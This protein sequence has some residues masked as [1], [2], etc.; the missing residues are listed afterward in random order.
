MSLQ[1]R[2]H[3]ISSDAVTADIM[4]A[5]DIKSHNT[6]DS[7]TTTHLQIPEIPAHFNLGFVV[8]SSGSGKSTLARRWSAT[9]KYKLAKQVMRWDETKAIASHFATSAEAIGK[10]NGVG[11]N[12]VKS[13]LCPYSV[14]SG[15]ERSRADIARQL[16]D[17]MIFDEYTSNIDRA[18]ACT[19]SCSL[20]K[21]IRRNNISNVIL[22]GVNPDVIPFLA[23]DWVYCVDRHEFTD[24]SGA[25]QPLDIEVSWS[26][27]PVTP[28][29][30]DKYLLPR[31]L[32]QIA[33]VSKGEWANFKQYHYLSG[34]LLNNSWVFC[35]YMNCV[36]MGQRATCGFIA[37]APL[38]MT[39]FNGRKGAREHR[40]VV[41]PAYQGIGL[42]HRI[43]DLVAKN[44]TSL[45]YNYYAVTSH[46]AIGEYRNANPN[47]WIPQPRN[48]TI[49]T[50]SHP[51]RRSPDIHEDFVKGERRI[52]SHK[53]AVT[54][55]AGPH[56]T[57]PRILNHEV[58]A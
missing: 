5:F 24:T 20:G 41:L 16:K 31:M 45:G 42:G 34:A 29:R 39:L 21:Y 55:W 54:E 28:P 1:L 13:W 17:E 6:P 9:T 37:V 27:S 15:G 50:L 33:P 18:S 49:G 26:A 7:E 35:A 46:P 52:Y 25:R 2:H 40:L 36:S 32:L 57:I 30:I 3:D 53:Y 58:K 51:V 38:P 22:C 12:S 11:L 8:G 48:N 43:S 10:L 14:L 23:P 56:G 19:M 47:I 4:K 44:I